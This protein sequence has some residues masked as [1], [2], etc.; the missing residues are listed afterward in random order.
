MANAVRR[1]VGMIA[2]ADDS[3][4]RGGETPRMSTKNNV[5]FL[6]AMSRPGP[7]FD[8]IL[9]GCNRTEKTVTRLHF[10]TSSHQGLS[11]RSLAPPT[12]QLPPDA[13]GPASITVI[14]PEDW[15]VTDSRLAAYEKCPRRF[16]YTHVLELGGAR[17]ATAFSRTHDCLY[18]LIHWL[19]HARLGGDPSIEAAEEEFAAIWQAA[20][21]NRSRLRSRLSPP[22]I[23]TR[24]ALVR[25]GAG[26]RFCEAEPI[27]IDFTNGRVLVEPERDG[28]IAER[29]R[30]APSCPHRP[31]AQ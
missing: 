19:S 7:I 6:S 30:S 22:C 9:P 17:K 2:G 5:Y 28:Q 31:Q 10:S 23:P 16:F 18:E 12:L 15:H 25:A 26:R 14:R 3:R 24:G 29:H 20:W 13:F 27:A 8:S 1:R 21:P 4:L 11:A